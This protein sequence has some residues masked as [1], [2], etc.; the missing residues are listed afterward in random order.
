MHPK[1]LSTTVL[2]NTF[3]YLSTKFRTKRHISSIWQVT[4]HFSNIYKQ[5]TCSYIN[6]VH[7][8]HLSYEHNKLPI[9][10]QFELSKPGLATYNGTV[11]CIRFKLLFSKPSTLLTSKYILLIC[12]F[13]P[14]ISYSSFPQWHWPRMHTC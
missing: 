2:Y 11:A 13:S 3:Y 4:H 6:G 12:Y 14:E 7:T 10:I 9:I 5:K 8:N 1:F